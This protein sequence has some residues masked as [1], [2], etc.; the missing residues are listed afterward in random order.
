MSETLTSPAGLPP[1]VPPLAPPM[2]AS[3]EV[4][5][6]GDQIAN[7]SMLDAVQLG[8]YLKEAHNLDP[9]STAVA[10]MPSVE[11]KTVV[12]VQTTFDVVIKGF[13]PA[14]KMP[15][16]KEVRAIT[17]LG[18]GESKAFVEAAATGPKV[19]KEGIEKIEA[20]KLKAT[21]EAAGAIV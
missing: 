19:V 21:L 3:D 1:T 20:E 14:K 8:K 17:A 2:A 4:R 13:D 5:S 6:L 10:V 18:L 15:V 7:L 16:I 11:T 9:V 12:P